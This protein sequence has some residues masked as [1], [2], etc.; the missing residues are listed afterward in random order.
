[1]SDL[2]LSPFSRFGRNDIFSPS[3]RRSAGGGRLWTYIGD[4]ADVDAGGEASLVGR[5][6]NRVNLWRAVWF[7]LLLWGR[8]E[9]FS[10]A[11]GCCCGFRWKGNGGF[12]VVGGSSAG[13]G[14]AF[15]VVLEGGVG[16]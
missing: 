16:D 8:A 5:K 11:R 10:C 14:V 6:Q 15:V 2:L 3:G 13:S 4:G 1:M 7:G 12:C 9:V